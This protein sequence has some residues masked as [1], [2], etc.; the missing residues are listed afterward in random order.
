VSTVLRDQL[1]GTDEE[2]WACVTDG[3]RP[4]R[5][6]PKVPGRS[7]PA[8]LVLLLIRKVGVDE[9]EVAAMSKAEAGARLNKYWAEGV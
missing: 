1:Q 7:L 8:E 6:E 9:A 4:D 3:V 2:F 5:G